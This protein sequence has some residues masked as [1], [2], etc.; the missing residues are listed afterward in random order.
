MLLC[1]KY[2]MN[3]NVLKSIH[4]PMFE[5]HLNYSLVGQ[6]Q[7]NNLNLKKFD[8]AKEIPENYAFLWKEMHINLVSL[9]IQRS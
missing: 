8:L 1:P 6:A 5:S 7:N 9:K 3:F 4:R 2:F